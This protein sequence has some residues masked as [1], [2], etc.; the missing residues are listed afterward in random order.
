MKDFSEIYKTYYP[1]LFRF[2]CDFIPCHEDAENLLHDAFIELWKNFG[3]VD[4]I[5][6]INAYMFRLVR[7][8]CLDYL[9][10]KVHERAYEEQAVIEYRAGM[11][12]LDSMGDEQ[13][14]VGEL[15]DV[16]RNTVDQLPP[17]CKEIFIM[18]RV[19]GLGRNEIAERLELSAN[20]VSVQLGIALR[21]LREVTDRYLEIRG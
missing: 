20:T 19:D 1:K 15:A 7:N 13:L 9:K 18:S 5:K 4:T 2:A 8:K 6:N 10:H 16:I 12:V 17:R 14:M 3:H 21:R 11:D